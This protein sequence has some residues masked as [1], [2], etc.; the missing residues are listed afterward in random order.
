MLHTDNFIMCIKT[1]DFQKDVAKN[2]KQRLDAS[3]FKVERRLLKGKNENVFSMMKDELV[4]VFV[5]EFV[6]LHAK[7]YS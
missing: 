4:G 7:M 1:A 2:V 6:E 3:N 5:K